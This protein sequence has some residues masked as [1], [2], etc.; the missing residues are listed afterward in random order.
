VLIL[1]I[2]KVLWFDTLSQVFILNG[3]LAWRFTALDLC[4][5]LEGEADA[6]RHFLER[7]RKVRR[8]ESMEAHRAQTESFGG[9][10][11][12]RRLRP[13]GGSADFMSYS[14]TK[15][16]CYQEKYIVSELLVRTDWEVIG[17]ARVTPAGL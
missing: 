17:G 15:L 10:G 14:S 13:A 8:A 1:K 7:V 3:L 6:A 12:A 11:F 16:A 4:V 2:V 9:A 5:D